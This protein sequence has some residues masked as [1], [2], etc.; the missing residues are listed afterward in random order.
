MRTVKVWDLVVR[1]FHWGLALA[2][3]ASF[4]T[5][6]K[7]AW[8][9]VHVRI[10]LAVVALVV[11]R[12]AWGVVGPRP[13]R[14][15]SFVR[16]PREVLAYARAMLR[17]RPPAHLGHN[18]LGGAMVVA[19]LGVLLGLAATG[20]IAYAGPEFQGPLTGL[21]SRR[22][23]KGVKEV[24]EFLSGALLTLVAVHVAGVLASS[25]LE[26]QNLVAGM[27]DGRKQG[28]TATSTS[29]S[30]PTS[31]PT[32]TLAAT[33]ATF[34]GAL[35]S[36]GLGVAAALGLA[37]LLGLPLKAHA[38]GPL[39]ADLLRKYEAAA[40]AA[41]PAFAGFTAA[42]G[43]RIYL[44]EQVQDGQRVSCATCHTADPRRPGRTP[45]GKVVE[46]LAPAA[47]P[48]RFTDRADV[49]KWFKRNCKQVM[50]RECTPEE[51]GHFLTY[52]LAP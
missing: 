11:M 47:N 4:L 13:A 31:I 37:F 48:A 12:L 18:P 5:S 46:P 8:V 22:A 33:A 24:H 40:R 3:L 34:A 16:G 14:F 25:L 44:A 29:T 50:G 38:A 6:D 20:A 32:T 19:L 49:E 15:T 39:T 21:L 43:R 35:A 7:D 52:L 41:R 9:P 45:I 26:G 23:A 1:S 10:G 36:L 28:V 42:E 27:I 30:I 17:G 51:K 2:V